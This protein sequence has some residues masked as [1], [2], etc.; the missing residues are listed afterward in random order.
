MEISIAFTNICK[1]Y[2]VICSKEHEVQKCFHMLENGSIILKRQGKMWFILQINTMLEKVPLGEWA[3]FR[4]NCKRLCSHMR[5]PHK[6]TGKR[7]IMINISIKNM[8]LWLK[9]N[10]IYQ[11][12]INLNSSS[13]NKKVHSFVT[14]AIKWSG[15][16]RFQLTNFKTFNHSYPSLSVPF[17]P[18]EQ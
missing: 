5:S 8:L 17:Q 10:L 16:G 4:V 9:Y 12:Q 15:G 18:R 7:S 3:T 2:G 14:L 6:T 13:T 11:I 1:S